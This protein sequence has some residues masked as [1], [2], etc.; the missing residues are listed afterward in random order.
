MM[1]LESKNR[2]D[3]AESQ[4]RYLQKR[5][6]E[7]S[8]DIVNNQNYQLRV[9]SQLKTGSSSSIGAQP[10]GKVSFLAVLL[11]EFSQLSQELLD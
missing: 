3:S 8:N 10:S 5:L 11:Q 6:T 1:L 7:L 9:G 4:I 2:D